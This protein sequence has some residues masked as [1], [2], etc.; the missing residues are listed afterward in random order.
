MALRIRRDEA[1][2]PQRRQQGEPRMAEIPFDPIATWQKFVSDWEKQINE[3]SARVTGTEE[4]SSVMNQASKF[5]MAARQQFDRQMEE[6]LKTAHLPSKSDVAAIH[7]RLAAIEDAIEQL[8]LSLSRNERRAAP[9]VARTRK[10][11]ETQ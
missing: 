7:D 6:F 1:I 9:A 11:P 4:F 3:A 8:R 10:A 2:I 5:S